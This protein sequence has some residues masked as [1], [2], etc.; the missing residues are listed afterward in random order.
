RPEAEGDGSERTEANRHGAVPG[1][2]GGDELLIAAY[3]HVIAALPS[4]GFER[5]EHRIR[6]RSRRA[7][8]LLERTTVR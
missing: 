8:I 7:S 1:A 4:N 5:F 3:S 2:I 6:T